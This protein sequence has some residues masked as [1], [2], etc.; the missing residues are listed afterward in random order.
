MDMSH[1]ICSANH[2]RIDH[3]QIRDRDNVSHT[4]IENVLYRVPNQGAQSVRKT[5]NLYPR[6]KLDKRIDRTV[7]D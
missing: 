3:I 2:V 4:M 7:S 6:R 1:T 5:K